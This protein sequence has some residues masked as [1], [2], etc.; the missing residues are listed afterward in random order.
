[1]YVTLLTNEES[2]SFEFDK[3]D[4]VGA[5]CE[6]CRGKRYV[7]N[8]MKRR[9]ERNSFFLSNLCLYIGLCLYGIYL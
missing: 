4:D 8:I 7:T 1:M 2:V 5:H 9:F 6:F 3:V